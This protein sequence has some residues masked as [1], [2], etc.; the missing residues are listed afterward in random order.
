M[1]KTYV[2]ISRKWH[3]PQIETT[4]TDESIGLKK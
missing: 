4:I 1:E 2:T 3:K